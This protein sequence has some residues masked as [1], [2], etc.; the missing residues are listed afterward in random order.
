MKALI[1]TAVLTASVLPAQAEQLPTDCSNEG[2]ERV[3]VTD[4][5]AG[6]TWSVMNTSTWCDP[7]GGLNPASDP[8]FNG[9]GGGE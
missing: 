7:V 1:L 4:N 8:A 5:D 9:N 3:L 6:K 2:R